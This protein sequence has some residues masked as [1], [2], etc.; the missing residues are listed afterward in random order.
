MNSGFVQSG[1]G[2]DVLYLIVE[3]QREGIDIVVGACANL[4]V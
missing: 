4:A 3:L 2:I 1:N